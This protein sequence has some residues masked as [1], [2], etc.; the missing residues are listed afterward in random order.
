MKKQ[1]RRI[2]Y[3]DLMESFAMLFVVAYH[4]SNLR[5][6]PMDDFTLESSIHYYLR[7]IFV[8]CVPL[9]LITNGYLLF[10]RPLDGKQHLKKILHYAVL[11]LFWGVVTLLV[12]Y[13]V[14]SIPFTLSG[15]VTELFQWRTGVIYLWYMGALVIIYLL[16]P[17]LKLAYDQEERLFRYFILMVAFFTFGNQLLNHTM[18]LIRGFRGATMYWVMMENWFSMFNPVPEIPG[19]TLVYFC[20]GAY[21]QDFLDYL[22][23]FSRR[24][25]N[26]FAIG[27]IMLAAAI[28]AVWFFLLSKVTNSYCCSIWY[29][30]ETITGFI[31]SV[32]MVS[33]LGNYR[34]ARSSV[35][36]GFQ[37]ISSHTLGIYF[38]HM[39]LVYSLRQLAF[40]FS[41]LVN[42]AGNLLWAA[43]IV[44]LCLG[45]VLGMKKIP[46]IRHL[47]T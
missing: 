33:L 18:T 23:R 3:I 43:G 17:L 42:L 24:K 2:P 1:T 47:V 27:V 38:I 34:G 8:C 25:R 31:I 22:Q 39:V 35:A 5:Y 41:P 30:Y 14:E 46:G 37:L 6:K 15:F 10:H 45:L 20:L 7:G 21:L 13:H 32:A 19:Y 29:G 11:T 36:H 16:F 44:L 12:Y 9:F 4:L 26:G 40:S 28:H